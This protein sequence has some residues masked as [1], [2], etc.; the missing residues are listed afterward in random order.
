MTTELRVLDESAWD[1]WFDTLKWAFGGHPEIAERRALWREVTEIDRS[2]AMWDGDRV[3]GTTGTFSFRLSVPGGSLVRTGALTMVSVAATHRRQG[4]LRRMMRRQL[5]DVRAAGEP[6]AILTASEPVIYGRFGYGLATQYVAARLDTGRV[7][8][9]LPEGTGEVRLSVAEPSEVSGRCEELY[10]RQVPCR[11]GM[12]AR[13]PGW[14]KVQFADPEDERRG[15]SPLR[16]LLAE[17]DGEL[18]GYALYNMK[19][20]WERGGPSGVVQVRALEAAGP[21][22]HAALLRF[23]CGID[24]MTSVRLSDRPV[25]DAFL[26]LVTDTRRCELELGDSLYLRPV[27]VGAALAARSYSTD[28]DVVLEVSDAFCPWNEGRWHLSGGPKGAVCEPTRDP[29]D[30]VL[31]ANELGS[32]YLG[33]FSLTALAS[34]GRVREV[35]PGALA[36]ASTAFTSPVAPWLPHGF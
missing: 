34:A 22:D 21:A 11:P 33:G 7:G 10:A 31:S 23:L 35:R 17:R 30:L 25:D 6:L 15:A 2:L 18:T 26:H 20:E 14:T 28:I 13:S 16:A 19:P 4:I 32:A 12:L 36:A 27:E 1:T 24:L 3:V 9:R 29:A 5:D 8:L